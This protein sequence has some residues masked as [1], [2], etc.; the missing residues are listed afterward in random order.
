MLRQM[1]TGKQIVV[2][3]GAHDALTAKKVEHEQVTAPTTNTAQNVNAPVKP[4]ETAV[5]KPTAPS[6]F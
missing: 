5:E 3:P 2:A 6:Y 4:T 1:M